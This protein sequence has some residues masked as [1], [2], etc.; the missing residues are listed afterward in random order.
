MN[1]QLNKAK[2]EPPLRATATADQ[3][4]KDEPAGAAFRL[5]DTRVFEKSQEASS[6]PAF[7]YMSPLLENW[8]STR[9]KSP[10]NP[11]A[12]W[13]SIVSQVELTRPIVAGEHRL[14]EATCRL[15][16]DRLIVAPPSAESVH[17][18]LANLVAARTRPLSVA[19][20]LA[21]W[22]GLDVDFE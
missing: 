3:D 9:G 15:E 18:C 16:Y 5:Q 22:P 4:R 20:A 11:G 8:A 1:R 17:W 13:L 10:A 14:R 2:K 19:A 7:A 12:A 6:K 21:G